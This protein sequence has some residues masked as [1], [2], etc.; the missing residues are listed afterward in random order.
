MDVRITIT[1]RFQLPCDQLE[2]IRWDFSDHRIFLSH[3]Q[4]I[5]VIILSIFHLCQHISVFILHNHIFILPFLLGKYAVK[6]QVNIQIAVISGNGRSCVRIIF[7][8]ERK[9]QFILDRSAALITEIIH[10]CCLRRSSTIFI[11]FYHRLCK[12]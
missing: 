12:L 4:L 11:K 3:L 7:N 1:Y 9:P 2:I 5:T 6:I 10:T 8:S